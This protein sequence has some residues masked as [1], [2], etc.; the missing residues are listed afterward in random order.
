MGK[1]LVPYVGGITWPYGMFSTWQQ[2]TLHSQ[3]TV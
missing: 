3:F 1:V 2:I